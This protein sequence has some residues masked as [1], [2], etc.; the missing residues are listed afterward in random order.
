MLNIRSLKL[1]FLVSLLASFTVFAIACS[2]E[3]EV[4]EP[5]APAAPAAAAAPA[6]RTNAAALAGAQC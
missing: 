6:K 4:T 3:E 5:A 1:Y 2:S